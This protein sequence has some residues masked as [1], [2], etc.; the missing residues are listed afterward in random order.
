M[1][2]NE[3]LA[4]K[5]GMIAVEKGILS[6]D[7]FQQALKDQQQIPLED[8]TRVVLAEVLLKKGFLSEIQY[9]A[10]LH[11]AGTS[12]AAEL[13]PA[14]P[15]SQG[16][17][18]IPEA[19]PPSAELTVSKDHFTAWLTTDKVGP[20]NV[21]LQE[22]KALLDE[23]GLKY[24][25]VDD[26]VITAYLEQTQEDVPGPE[27]EPV[28]IEPLKIAQGKP[29]IPGVPGKAEYFFN[30]NPMHIGTEK[31]DGTIDWK[32]HGKIPFVEKNILVATFTPGKEG[33]PGID[34]Y[35]QPLL[36]PKIDTTAPLCDKGV[37]ISEDGRE[38][39]S[40][41]KGQ[42]QLSANGK[43]G[44]FPSLVIDGD[45]GVKTGHVE[46]DGHI[47][48]NGI[49][50]SGYH[51][52]GTSLHA[53]GALDADINTSGDIVFTEGLFG[54]RVKTDGRLKA[55]HI[56]KSQIE[57]LDDVA[58][59]SE[60]TESIVVT[61]GKFITD[62]A[63][64]SSEISA[65]K[66]I[67]AGEIGSDAA[68]ASTLTVGVDFRAIGIDSGLRMKI[69]MKKK[70]VVKVNE[71]MVQLQQR[72]DEINTKLGEIAQTQDH[73]MQKKRVLSQ[74][75][76]ENSREPA[77][78]S[79][80][81]MELLENKIKEI[82]KIVEDMMIE[83]EAALEQISEN[84]NL[85]EVLTNE[86]SV[87]KNKSL[88]IN[89]QSEADPGVAMVQVSGNIYPGTTIKGPRASFTIP[90]LIQRAVIKE[91]ENKEPGTQPGWQMKIM[92]K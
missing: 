9:T 6:R 52:Y 85:S 31:A 64:L 16:S 47:E 20:A 30:T 24:G 90:E 46:F 18:L 58:I 84:K 71:T 80:N 72:S 42:P 3:L 55:G 65:K 4:Q 75:L 22:I 73:H 28:H 60:I 69:S 49:I 88:T 14:T 79:Q 89:E 26:A 57:A 33:E 63:L 51:V 83:D 74:A 13:S 56:H 68:S 67:K 44:I 7:E 87:L 59:N 27:G 40:S 61:S 19:D 43:I 32:N 45:V 70:E 54:T 38:Y 41:E 78:Q 35:M 10:I 37:E 15:D 36:P 29:A 81:Q 77:K 5:V 17:E 2:K 82:D 39:S 21:T 62:G 76:E 86:I 25:I 34:L 8:P 91:E 92:T 48:V 66:G 1:N 23:K 11:T 12:P 50:D 53:K